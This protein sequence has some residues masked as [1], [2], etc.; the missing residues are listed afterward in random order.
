MNLPTTFSR[1][2]AHQV[3]AW[4]AMLWL[5]SVTAIVAAETPLPKLSGI[6]VIAGR[7]NAL[8]EFNGAGA[9]AASQIWLELGERVYGC[10]LLSIDPRTG[11]VRVNVD[12]VAST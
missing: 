1:R 2:F 12:G 8:L 6:I 4:C 7:T 3:L 5:A 11:V 9:R 10:E